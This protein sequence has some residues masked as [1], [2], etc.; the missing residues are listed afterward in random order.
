MKNFLKISAAVLGTAVAGVLAW[1][2]A[3]AKQLDNDLWAQAEKLT[4]SQ[5]PS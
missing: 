2:A 3:E 5:R 1:R 4:D